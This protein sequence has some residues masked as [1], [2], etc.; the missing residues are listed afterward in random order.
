MANNIKIENL[1]STIQ[2]ELTLYSDSITKHT[3][4][5]AKDIIKQLVKDTKKDANKFTGAYQKAITYAKTFESL[6]VISY[7]WFVKNPQYRLSHLLEYGHAKRNGGR[8]KAY[9]FISKNENI[10]I[11]N[12]EKKIKE[13]VES[14]S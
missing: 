11:A 5:I 9:G 2:K 14:E 7:T 1:S 12:Y 8:T 4:I 3:K 13:M 6:R 10:A